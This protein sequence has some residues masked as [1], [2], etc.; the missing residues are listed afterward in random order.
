[1]EQARAQRGLTALSDR[2]HVTRSTIAANAIEAGLKAVAKRL[3]RAARHNR[4]PSSH[5][6]GAK[7]SA[8]LLLATFSVLLAGCE[9]AAPKPPQA[10]GAQ[11][12]TAPPAAQ[13]VELVIAAAKPRTARVEQVAGGAVP[14][15]THTV[16]FP[17]GFNAGE[18][19][20]V[21][22]VYGRWYR[23]VSKPISNVVTNAEVLRMGGVSLDDGNAWYLTSLEVSPDL[24]LNVRAVL[25][26]RDTPGASATLVVTLHADHTYYVCYGPPAE[27]GLCEE[28]R[29]IN[30]HDTS[31]ANARSVVLEQ[32]ATN[33]IRLRLVISP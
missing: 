33:A 30:A 15:R 9:E 6:G 11:E 12:P 3:R 29:N 10:A 24:W 28:G 18:R 1:M 4:R 20:D 13:V 7:V 2:Y 26:E 23:F 22:N 32:L 31:E 21:T 17:D 16:T 5:G 25:V 8:A 19:Y 27:Q 14:A